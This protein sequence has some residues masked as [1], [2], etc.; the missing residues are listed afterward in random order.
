MESAKLA[1]GEV[2]RAFSMMRTIPWIDLLFSFPAIRWD[3]RQT[4][5][6][7]TSKYSFPELIKTEAIL[8]QSPSKEISH[9]RTCEL[10]LLLSTCYFTS[11]ST[12]GATCVWIGNTE[13]YNSLVP[14]DIF[15]GCLSQDLVSL[16]AA[17]LLPKVAS[18]SMIDGSLRATS[19]WLGLTGYLMY[20][21]GIYVFEAVVNKL[22]LVYIFIFGTC[23]WTIIV[24]RY[25]I[26]EYMSFRRTS[27]FRK[28]H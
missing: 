16:V 27:R 7:I 11:I 13:I 21:Y 9:R 8:K 17:L 18:R 3:I 19:I 2:I 28:R 26:S 5:S 25:L 20:A 4:A 22:Y 12:I 6:L 14:D 1:F 23:L 24:S 15:P 10:P